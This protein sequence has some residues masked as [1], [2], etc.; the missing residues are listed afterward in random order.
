METC[1]ID[2]RNALHEKTF[3]KYNDDPDTIVVDELSLCQGIVRVDI[4]VINGSIN[5][6]EIKS[7][8]DTLER[9]S[10]QMEYY[11]K[12]LDKVTVVVGECHLDELK[13]IIPDWC[14]IKIAEKKRTGNVSIRQLKKPKQNPDIIP[15]HVAQLLWKNEVLEILT[16]FGLEKGYLSKPREILW[17]RLS[18]S[19]PLYRLQDY[20]RRYLKTRKNWRVDLQ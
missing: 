18:E 12:V 3:C 14:G 7:E 2:I 5:G 16:E 4:A 10:V 17:K 11:S 8:K 9:L 13:S 15:Y 20:V 6:Y 19:L 1:D